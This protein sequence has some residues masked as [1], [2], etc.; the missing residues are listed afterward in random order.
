MHPMTMFLPWLATTIC[1]LAVGFIHMPW[2]ALCWVNQA[3]KH[4]YLSLFLPCSLNSTKS[5]N[6]LSFAI[7]P[8]CF[9]HVLVILVVAQWSCFVV[10]DM[11]MLSVPFDSM[12]CS[13]SIYFCCLK[14][15]IMTL[16][17]ALLR[18]SLS[19]RI[20]YDLLT[21]LGE[22]HWSRGYMCWET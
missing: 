16:F 2:Y 9:E 4:V 21:C 11:Y 3:C 8:W 13:C 14:V 19:L 15:F 20:C 18:Y 22:C 7:L 1:L 12:K 5:V 17:L 10:L 6:L